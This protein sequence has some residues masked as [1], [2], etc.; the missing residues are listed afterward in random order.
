MNHSNQP[1]LIV[2][3]SL[4]TYMRVVSEVAHNPLF[5]LC[6]VVNPCKADACEIYSAC[7]LHTRVAEW[8][9][10]N[11]IINRSNYRALKPE[12]FLQRPQGRKFSPGP[13]LPPLKTALAIIWPK[14][15]ASKN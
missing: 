11:Y 7:A 6:G 1:L 9:R 5:V 10:L 8:Q 15:I 13:S 2:I 3:K 14:S 12:I 4:H